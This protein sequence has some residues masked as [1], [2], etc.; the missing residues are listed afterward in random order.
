MNSRLKVKT[1]SD[2]E[3]KLNHTD[4]DQGKNW[5][6]LLLKTQINPKLKVQTSV[7]L[8]PKIKYTSIG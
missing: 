1:G 7:G 3:S 2:F 8:N 4:I 6:R 5:F